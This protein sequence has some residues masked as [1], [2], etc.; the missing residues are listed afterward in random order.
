LQ[1]CTP[2]FS[3]A[4]TTIR[5]LGVHWLAC[6][7]LTFSTLTA[8]EKSI[9]T[10]KLATLVHRAPCISRALLWTKPKRTCRIGHALPVLVHSAAAT[11]NLGPT[12]VI[13][14]AVEDASRLVWWA[15]LGLI[16]ITFRQLANTAIP[17]IEQSRKT[18]KLAIEV[19]LAYIIQS[20]LTWVKRICSRDG[21]TRT[22][23]EF[24]ANATINVDYLAVE[25]SV[26][27][28]LA[29]RTRGAFSWASHACTVLENAAAPAIDIGALKAVVF[30]DMQAYLTRR[31]L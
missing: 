23:L 14:G 12:I 15:L 7:A 9:F 31:T 27:A 28:L 3:L 18:T 30:G 25:L 10:L 11:V 8:I 1:R 4:N 19:L 5:T 16:T 6:A 24:S 26:G 21:H 17:T 29:S 2:A 13:S 22:V 20:A